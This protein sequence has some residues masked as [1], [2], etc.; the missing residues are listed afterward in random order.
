MSHSLRS[1]RAVP[2]LAALLLSFAGPA[3]ASAQVSAVLSGEAGGTTMLS[4]HQ[5]DTL[6][7]DNG[8][9]GSVRPGLRFADFF[10]VELS[11]GGLWFPSDAGNASIFLLGGGLRLEPMLGTVGRLFIDGHAHYAYTG[12]LSR[13]SVDGGI[14]FEFQA[15]DHAS[16]GPYA[17]YTH[18]FTSGP[19]DG[20]DAMMIS[21]G[22]SVSIGA[23]RRVA[24]PDQDG[25]GVADVDDVCVDVAAGP[26]PDP[27]RAGCPLIDTDRDGVSDATDVCPNDAAGRTP[28][29]ERAGC[30]LL[31]TDGDHVSDRLDLCPNEPRGERPDPAREGCPLSDTD[32]DGIYDASDVC[33]TT[34]IG[35]NPDPNRLGCP[36]GD[37][38]DDGVRNALDQCPTEHEHATLHPDPDR[39]G[40][41]LADRDHD[42]VPDASDACPD[43]AGAPNRV[44]RRH[45][46]P[47]ILVVYTDH[48]AIEE[49]VYFATGRDRILPRSRRVLTAL[50]EALRLTPGIRRLSIVGHTD[51]V[52]TAEANRDLAERRA[53]SVMRWLIE[54]EVDAARLEAH[55]LGE[56]DPS[57]EGTS[58]D[59]REEN[60]RVEFRIIGSAPVIVVGGSL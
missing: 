51:D 8:I 6:G 29:P 46:C 4:L 36:D 1:T 21:Y 39:P 57:R 3:A 47:G 28:D 11:V 19:N 34:V 22:L 53:A 40:C 10:R 37:D 2:L 17:R 26:A 9:T 16:I 31:D 45:G 20:S 49:P 33:P 23:S 13:I 41:P 18:V 43:Q 30:P 55:G 5:R 7:L 14:G 52:G 44:A 12:D 58:A 60:R 38:D 56:A 32:G 50:A 42:S 59:A 48:I 15:G 54:H 25:D 24:P 27:Q 35:A